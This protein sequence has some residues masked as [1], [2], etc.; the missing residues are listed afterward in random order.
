MAVYAVLC[1]LIIVP[2]A[3][4]SSFDQL[5]AFGDG[6]DHTVNYP[7]LPT[8]PSSPFSYPSLIDPLDDPSFSLFTSSTNYHSGFSE[9]PSPSLAP[10]GQTAVYDKLVTQHGS[11]IIGSMEWSRRLCDKRR[12]EKCDLISSTRAAS[13]NVDTTD[14]DNLCPR[15]VQPK[16]WARQEKFPTPCEQLGYTED[17]EEEIPYNRPANNLHLPNLVGSISITG[18]VFTHCGGHSFTNPAMAVHQPSEHSDDLEKSKRQGLIHSVPLSLEPKPKALKKLKR[19][20]IP[21]HMMAFSTSDFQPHTSNFSNNQDNFTQALPPEKINGTTSHCGPG[22]NSSNYYD[23]SNTI[24]TNASPDI[25]V[26]ELNQCAERKF[27]VSTKWGK[28]G[29][30]TRG[31]LDDLDLGRDMEG[32]AG[33][34]GCRT[35]NEYSKTE[36]EDVNEEVVIQLAL[37]ESNFDFGAIEEEASMDIS[38]K[39]MVPQPSFGGK[40]K[41]LSGKWSSCVFQIPRFHADLCIFIAYHYVQSKLS[42]RCLVTSNDT[43]GWSSVW[44]V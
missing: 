39:T 27:L 1:K 4:N 12:L 18:G 15:R 11:T 17:L 21:K 10:P 36:N 25:V 8:L 41:K 16:P 38:V 3:S 24:W 31:T 13:I 6:F 37:T 7:H 34:H 2:G 5:P 22:V 43:S 33:R 40:D 28:A 26:E 30:T 44:F 20:L 35:E 14:P 23:I 32:G 9:S 19:R 29:E 42:D